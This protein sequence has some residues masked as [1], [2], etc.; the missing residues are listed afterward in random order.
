MNPLHKWLNG[1]C[2]EKRE[3]HHLGS[4][5]SEVLA[6]IEH[7]EWNTRNLMS[8]KNGTL[9]VKNQS[10]NKTH[11]RKDYLTHTFDFKYDEEAKCPTWIKFIN[12]TFD[13]NQELIELLLMLSYFCLYLL[14]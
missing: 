13:N 8:F 6:T 5:I 3:N 4:V 12:E 2:W 9:D 11:N 1:M 7:T 10:F 14:D